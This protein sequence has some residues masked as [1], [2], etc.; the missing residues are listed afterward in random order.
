MTPLCFVFSFFFCF[1]FFIPFF[2][3]SFLFFGEVLVF[4]LLVHIDIV[5]CIFPFLLLPSF[6]QRLFTLVDQTVDAAKLPVA[7]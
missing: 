3:V 1:Y 2:P 5:W 4:H 6:T 7:G